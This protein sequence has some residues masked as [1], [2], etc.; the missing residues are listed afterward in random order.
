MK[1]TK[2]MNT[3]QQ[4][5]SAPLINGRTYPLWQQFVDRANEW[6]GGTL[7]DHDMGQVA[8]TKITGI[9]L[10]PNGKENAYFKVSGEEFDCAFCTSVGGVTSG[11]PGW[12]TFCG[13]GGHTWRIKK[14]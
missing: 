1:P 5:E 11:E 9:S 8:S 6:I 3:E 12:L 4:K 7:E 10:S 13:Y 2:F 14:P